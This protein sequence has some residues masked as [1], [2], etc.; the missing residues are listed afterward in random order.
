MRDRPLFLFLFLDEE[1]GLEE[2]WQLAHGLLHRSGGSGWGPA[3][4]L[5]LGTGTSVASGTRAPSRAQTLSKEAWGL[6]P[7]LFLH[8]PDWLPMWPPGLSYL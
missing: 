1:M 4:G 8:L 5:P 6:T 2:L 3:G 7:A